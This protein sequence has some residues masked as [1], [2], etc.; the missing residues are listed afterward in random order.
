MS[1]DLQNY[2]ILKVANIIMVKQVIHEPPRGKTNNVVSDQVRHK[3]ACTVTE[4]SYKLEILD[5]ET[6]GA[7]RA[8][9]R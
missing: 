5:L 7:P 3:P 2:N 9:K 8:K 6:V 4:E 1:L